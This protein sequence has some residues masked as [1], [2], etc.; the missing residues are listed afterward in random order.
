MKNLIIIAL[1]I[2]L[3][4]SVAGADTKVAGLINEGN[5]YR[6]SND[7]LNSAGADG[8]EGLDL[9][10]VDE[11]ILK[12]VDCLDIVCFLIA[13]TGSGLDYIA[14]STDDGKKFEIYD[15]DT[16][17]VVA[18]TTDEELVTTLSVLTNGA[19][20][21]TDAD[22]VAAAIAAA[23]TTFAAMHDPSF[24]VASDTVAAPEAP[25][26]LDKISSYMPDFL[27]NMPGADRTKA[28]EIRLN[29][30][31]TLDAIGTNPAHLSRDFERF[32]TFNLMD[33]SYNFS[34]SGLTPSWYTEWLT[35]GGIWDNETRDAFAATLQGQHFTFSSHLAFPTLFGFRIGPVA[36]N[37]S[38]FS[39]V[40]F[41]LPGELLAQGFDPILLNDPIEFDGLEL[42]TIP[43]VAKTSIA[44]GQLIPTPIGDIG[45]GVGLSVYTAAGYLRAVSSELTI[46]ETE[47]SILVDASGE[48]WYTGAGIQGS[49]DSPNTDDLETSELIS[50]QTA[51]LDLGFRYDLQ[52]F[53]GQE[54]EVML[55]LQNLGA[56][57]KW[58]NVIHEAWSYQFH[59]P[60]VADLAAMS[61]SAR[62]ELESSSTE[63][64][65]TG[66][67]LEVS[68]PAVMGLT[69]IYQPV[70]PLLILMQFEKSLSSEDILHIQAA[71]QMKFQLSYYPIPAIDL[72]FRRSALL[73]VPVYT[74]G[75]GLHFG[76][77]DAGMEFNFHN[78][79]NAEA[80]GI[81]FGL[82]SSWHF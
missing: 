80:K 45:A 18:E 68:V 20:S 32:T 17:V 53:L 11:L 38:A 30:F 72:T 1:S 16:K 57:F 76:I 25:S 34:N 56:K 39:W 74:F 52:P 5:I 59:A 70:A 79:L 81:G 77:W 48:G 50:K 33:V 60:N 43:G 78:G 54:L 26:F 65:S 69:A 35:E 62:Q 24:G 51:G 2:L 8:V 63:V 6:W 7:D 12:S 27:T 3:I 21:G 49:I 46:L 31:R 73:N 37:M 75:A 15:A 66:G 13:A 14:M 58:D 4:M 47:D 71:P 36:L 64:L 40:N 55:S 23:D 22:A 9:S 41:T 67:E 19:G 10:A 61:D 29:E 28:Q 42:E 82:F 44:Y